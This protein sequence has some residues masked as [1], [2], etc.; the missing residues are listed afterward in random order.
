M[1]IIFLVEKKESSKE[2]SKK[3]MDA[4]PHIYLSSTDSKME[5]LSAI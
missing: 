4:S 1:N 5:V 2:L 3:S